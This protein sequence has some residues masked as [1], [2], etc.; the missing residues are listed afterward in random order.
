MWSLLILALLA[1]APNAAP[2]ATNEH[3]VGEKA[4]DDG[5]YDDA[6][7]SFTKL[8][9]A[10]P[11]DVGAHF[12]LAVAYSFLGRD[13]LA[14]PEYRKV[15]ELEPDVYEAH[16]NLGQ[17]LLRD[18]NAAEALPHLKRA[19]EQK[20]QEFR[21]AFYLGE[22]AADTGQW[23][24]AAGA[25]TAALAIDGKSAPAELGLGKALAQDGKLPDAEAHYRKAIA[26]D[27]KLQDYL[28]ELA[29]L[30]EKGSATD[31]GRAVAIYH[32]FPKSAAARERAGLLELRQ[33]QNADAVQDLEIVV[34]NQPTPTSRLAL[35]QAYILNKDLAKARP[36]LASVV[37][38]NAQDFELRMM[39][40]RVLRDDHKSAEAAKEF[41]AAAKIQPNSV[42]AWS[43]L[44]GMQILVEQYPAA[45]AALD[46]VKQLGGEKPGHVFFRATTLDH[47][48]QRKEAV[49]QYQA[50]LAVS[51]DNPDQEFQARQRVRILERE[52][53]R[54]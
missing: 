32:E 28:L 27:P 39:Y 17:V 21:A 41:L 45:L 51:K 10:N 8:V 1:Q 36:L 34:Q 4:L 35:A 9:A 13:A 5:R 49:E 3:S 11:A 24:D 37:E 16:I 29:Q 38:G 43:E 33:G 19:H 44:A 6:V 26:L 7:A 50:F 14:I 54:R 53:G 30:L 20:P 47:M 48:N 22:A 40:A 23:K 15:L 12:N 2:A 46:R 31:T 25:Y 18:K 52:L 42:E